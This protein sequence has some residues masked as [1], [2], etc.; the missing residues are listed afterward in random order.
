[1]GQLPVYY[2]K[3]NPRGHDYV[4]MSAAPLYP[5]GY[6][7]SFSNFEYN[8]LQVQT[9]SANRFEVIFLLKNA[10]IVDGTEVVQLYLRDELAL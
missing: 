2:N 5:F 8:K 10:G 4:E 9:K 6:G 7:K 3:K 1:M